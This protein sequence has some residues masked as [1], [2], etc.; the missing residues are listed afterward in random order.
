VD[1]RLLT[2][3]ERGRASAAE[4]GTRDMNGKPRRAAAAGGLGFSG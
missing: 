1:A 4:V 3:E 2:S